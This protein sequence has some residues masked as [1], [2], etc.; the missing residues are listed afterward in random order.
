MISQNLSHDSKV[1][2]KEFDLE[3]KLL[4]ETG[5]KDNTGT[6]V[7]DELPDYKYIDLEFDSFRYVRKTPTSRA[8]KVK[9]G[10]KV[11]RWAQF[12][13]GEKGILPSILVQLLKARSDTRKKQ[14]T[15]KDP[16]I[17]NIL[18]KRQLA[19][20]VTANSLYGQCGSPTSAFCEKDIAA[21]TTATGR[22]MI[23]YARRIIEEVYKARIY[24]LESGEKVKTN[25]EYIYGDTDSVF[26]TFNLENPQTGEKI[27][28]KPA[29]EITIEIAQD[30]AKLCSQWLKPPMELSYEKTLMPFILV[31]KKKYVGMLYET[32]P[33]KGKLK[34]MG[35]SIKRRDS[36][37]YL[38][39]VYG[40]ILNILMKE[41]N[42][43]KAIEFLD[44]SLSNLL[45]GEVS[46]DKLMM[47]KQLKSDYKNPTRMEHWVLS[48][49]I[50]K[51]DPGNK[52]KS[53]DRI[54]FLHFVNAE[55]KLNG[56]RIETPEFIEENKLPID[57]NYYITNQLMKPLQQL[58]S[59]ALEQIW[60]MNNKGT[61]L[62]KHRK[63]VAELEKQYEDRTIFMKKREILCCKKI[64]ELF[65]DKYLEQIRNEK[66]KTQMITNFFER[67]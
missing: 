56:E 46:K 19:Y 30:A 21:S 25:A 2:T 47:T 31:A 35:L 54:K 67:R 23:I 8:E 42:I 18:E 26:F 49:R 27:R 58:F 62:R 3:G 48:D 38:K 20:K 64:K 59:L 53:G 15:E 13:D 61:V 16:F 52:P 6:Y 50:G 9:C 17:W 22:M 34:Y 39:D 55:A 66:T 60:E 1:W 63:E 7:Y 5:E 36:C 45:K 33:N 65:F 14:K 4:R 51:R 32:D 29:L 41:Y 28:G 40:G 24:T 11:C 10:T 12:P 43:Q 37:D 57:Y 44:K